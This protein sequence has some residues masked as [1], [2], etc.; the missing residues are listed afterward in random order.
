MGVNL[1]RLRCR[2]R[3]TKAGE[4]NLGKK[5][6][7]AYRRT[8]AGNKIKF[9]L[10]SVSRVWEAC[11]EW[12]GSSRSGSYPPLFGE[13]YSTQRRGRPSRCNLHAATNPRDHFSSRFRAPRRGGWRHGRDVR[14]TRCWRKQGRTANPARR[15]HSAKVTDEARKFARR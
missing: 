9:V 4:M 7:I 8:I 10:T 11:R 14:G 2:E 6:T 13:L 12:Q 1:W 3:K 5:S 15:I